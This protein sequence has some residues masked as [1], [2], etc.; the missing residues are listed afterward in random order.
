MANDGDEPKKHD[1]KKPNEDAM[2]TDESDS[3]SSE[4]DDDGV[5]PPA[6]AKRFFKEMG[7]D[8]ARKMDKKVERVQRKVTKQVEEV[9]TKVT[10]RVD[11]I[12][13]QVSSFEKETRAEIAAIH[14][15]V[16]TGGNCVSKPTVLDVI[17]RETYRMDR[18]LDQAA[19]MEDTVIIGKH[20]S[21]SGLDF[22]EAFVKDAVARLSGD[23]NVSFGKRGEAYTVTFRRVGSASAEARARIFIT[24]VNAIHLRN[25]IWTQ[26]DMPRLLR[27]FDKNAKD[28]AR[29]FK[30]SVLAVSPSA[31]VFFEV[32]RGF[33][34]MND[35]VIG[36]ISMIP[37][38][39][40]WP[41][42]NDLVLELLKKSGRKKVDRAK[43]L[44][45]QMHQSV[46]Q[47][48]YEE[49]EKLSLCPDPGDDAEDDLE[50][51][52]V[53]LSGEIPPE[54]PRPAP[55]KEVDLFAPLP[56]VPGKQAQRT[57]T[58]K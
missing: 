48:L 56:K 58:S 55:T 40:T 33:L 9:E 36:P 47:Y 14:K 45:S 24:R 38:R 42:L 32:E 2:E 4:D 28:F 57:S 11:E 13:V 12:S 10:K 3:S 51:F 6:W 30:R 34:L 43:T 1:S 21:V 8:I 53:A 20:P 23:K 46:A 22:S 54:D 39:S 26:H 25:T 52:E 44:G 17:A 49:H 29:A 35:T 19:S 15:K 18:L 16:D 7:R 27:L 31:S 41:T 5:P 50:L 37:N